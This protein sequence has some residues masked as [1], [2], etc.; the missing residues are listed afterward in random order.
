MERVARRASA[1]WPGLPSAPAC[2]EGSGVGGVKTMDPLRHG[3]LNP[4]YRTTA[5]G[6]K[7]NA[8]AHECF[9]PSPRHVDTMARGSDPGPRCLCQHRHQH[10][11]ALSRQ[12]PGALLVSTGR[13]QG[14]DET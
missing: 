3:I 14:R 11:P 2:L 4:G 6:G 10:A 7:R 13:H 8:S 9:R 5:A 12:P 1:P